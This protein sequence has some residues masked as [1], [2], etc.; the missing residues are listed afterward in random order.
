MAA[1]VVWFKRD[2]RIHDHAPL[3]EAAGRGPV[4][5][6]YVAEP[7]LW[8][9]P[10]ASGRQ[11]AFCAESLADLRVQLAAL[12][13]PL[14]VRV[15]G[16]VEV[17]EALRLQGLV[18]GLW[19]HQ[20]TGNAWSYARDRQV[21]A[22]ARAR[23]LSWRQLP[24]GG[25]V[26]GLHERDGWATLWEERMA[27]PLL[28]PP[29]AVQAQLA[30]AGLEPGPLPSSDDLGLRHDPCPHR[31]PGGRHEGL[32]TL[33]SFLADRGWAYHRQL[34]S[35]LSAFE[36]CS[37]LSPHLAYGTLSLR[38]VVQACRARRRTLGQATDPGTASWRRALRAFEERLHWHCHF[39]QKLESQ[40]D[41]ETTEAHPA[42]I[43]LRQSDPA[44]L[45]AWAEGRTGLPFVDACMRALIAGGW[46]NFRMRAMLMAVASYHLWIDWRDSGAVLARLFV[47]YE[48]GIHWNQCQMQAGTTGINTVR[49]YN[50]IK[51]GRDHDPD[52][53]FIRR[54]LPELSA[55]PAVHLHE[56]W[57]MDEV[58]QER[59]G[60]RLGQDYPLPIVDPMEAAR[61][62]RERVWGL[63]QGPAFRAIAS[64]IHE[65]HGSRRG[66]RRRRDR[67]QTGSPQTT[68]ERPG[69]RRQPQGHPG[70]LSLDLGGAWGDP[71]AGGAEPQIR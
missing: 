30:L 4:L 60:C 64:A 46:I 54:W 59:A 52:G 13:L 57:T 61:Q 33:N 28:E 22:W 69:P 47:D 20:E 18:A 19:S 3:R 11:W 26:R 24:S 70:Q 35:P 10:D 49:I 56:T 7:E 2:L 45:A 16:A 6:L 42:Y 23:G 55:V 43:G 9:L 67:A 15:G 1:Q 40:P 39:I 38:E 71:L 31:H 63:R 37:R 21:A 25:V 5:P 34:S 58:T 36:A 50:P 53:R 27:Q 41:L 44:R 17:L 51:Q 66:S 14:V 65:R 48:S 29:A 32:R 12:G 68:R 8:S 62:A